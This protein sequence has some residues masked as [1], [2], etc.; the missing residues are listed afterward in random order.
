MNLFSAKV[1][2]SSY[3]EDC[4]DLLAKALYEFDFF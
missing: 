1:K 2:S 4:F 3:S